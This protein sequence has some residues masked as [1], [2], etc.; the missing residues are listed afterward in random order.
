LWLHIH[1]AQAPSSLT[2]YY[3]L[4]QQQNQQGST[5]SKQAT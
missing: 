1:L 5:S 2:N 3:D 4:P